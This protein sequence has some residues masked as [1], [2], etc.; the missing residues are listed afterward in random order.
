M[1]EKVFMIFPDYWFVPDIRL[2]KA[3]ARPC[4]SCG[5]R[6]GG[7][8][9]LS[10]SAGRTEKPSIILAAVASA[11]ARTEVFVKIDVDR[12]GYGP[13]DARGGRRVWLRQKKTQAFELGFE[14]T[15]GGGW[16]RH[17]EIDGGTWRAVRGAWPEASLSHS[18]ALSAPSFNDW[19][20]T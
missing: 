18:G 9:L 7:R 14:S 11:Q 17:W 5:P 10:S 12:R 15:K 1:A 6:V 13:P 20:Y 16:R 2:A 4:K 3:C 19:N 8:V